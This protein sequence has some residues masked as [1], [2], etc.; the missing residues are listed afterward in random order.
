VLQNL[1]INSIK[2]QQ[3]DMI[4]RIQISSKLNGDKVIIY[5]KDNG[6]GIDLPRYGAQLFGLYKRFDYSVEGKG[7]GLFMVKMQVESL[8]GTINVQSKLNTGTEF[9]LEFPMQDSN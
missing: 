1:V 3:A 6:K 5:V 4:P 8:G 2:Y 9:S 7:M